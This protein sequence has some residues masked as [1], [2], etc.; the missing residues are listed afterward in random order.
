M[1]VL[2]YSNT[3][4]GPNDP[5]FRADLERAASFH[6]FNQ[7]ISAWPISA[8]SL[9]S[10]KA[11]LSQTS[12]HRLKQ[13]SRQ[14]LQ[15]GFMA[16]ESDPV[17]NHFGLT[18][19]DKSN[20]K[21]SYQY[22][23][24][25]L[26]LQ[27]STQYVN[28][29]GTA[30][31]VQFDNTFINTNIANWTVGVGAI[32]RWWG[33]GWDSGLILSSNARPI[34]S[35][36]LTRNTSKPAESPWFKWMGPWTLV[37]FMGQL[38]QNRTV[39]NA[40]LWGLRLVFKPSPAW[41]LGLS[42]TAMWA[43][44]GRPKDLEVFTDLLVGSDNFS[45][46]SSHKSREPG[47]QLAGFDFKYLG[48][49]NSTGYSFYGEIIGEDEVRGRP[50]KPI[51]MFGAALHLLIKDRNLTLFSEY[52]DTALDAFK[53]NKIYDIAYRHGIYTTGYLHK[54]LPI[55]STYD[56]D[57]QTLVVGS[58]T[59]LENNYKFRLSARHLYLNRDTSNATDTPTN[60]SISSKKLK[61][62]Q[63]SLGLS[64][65]WTNI[66][67]DLSYLWNA[68]DSELNS[69]NISSLASLAVSLNI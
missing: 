62:Q 31:A 25:Y 47:N 26:D 23:N 39:P 32:D 43:G 60:S 22:L 66:S 54:G 11:Y 58:I 40:L 3:W 50:S 46:H 61:T 7:P 48:H 41:E 21:L 27:I 5:W 16:S 14:N 10:A 4:L 1:P 38:E 51:I 67:A 36:Y 56:N 44:D 33:P 34:P 30:S 64:K 49:V 29:H 8:H 68:N 9:N 42:R 28:N 52:S 2:A 15:L 57:S 20:T 13:S 53:S 55:G 45:P 12:L 35:L 6:Q 17:F 19:R 24:Q 59:N 37:S 65:S 63:L 18:N 69:D